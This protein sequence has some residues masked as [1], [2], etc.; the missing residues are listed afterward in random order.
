MASVTLRNKASVNFGANKPEPKAEQDLQKFL[1]FQ[2]SHGVIG[3]LPANTVT[4]IVRVSF[5]DVLP[6]PQMH[7][8]VMGILNWRSE[9][10]WMVDLQYL[11]G[12]SPTEAVPN[13]VTG[14]T[15]IAMFLKQRERT[16][17]LV[18]PLVEDLIE[19]DVKAMNPPARELFSG[20]SFS[21]LE[22]YFMSD[23]REI[24]M[25]L[26]PDAIF[27]LGQFG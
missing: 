24:M 18:I 2:L 10:V 19:L 21:F 3:L 22:G 27:A 8:C 15:S 26:K 23:R 9:M 1:R 17:G 25:S 4:E 13:S 12:Y 6:A 20:Q 11:L 16:L 14:T 7:P 5:D